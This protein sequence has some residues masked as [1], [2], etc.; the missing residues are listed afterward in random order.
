MYDNIRRKS[1]SDINEVDNIKLQ[2]GN[3]VEKPKLFFAKGFL[4]A[5]NIFEQFLRSGFE[6]R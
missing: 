3:N 6:S 4:K 5:L 2:L 1:F